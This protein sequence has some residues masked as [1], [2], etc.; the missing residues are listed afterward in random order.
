M[1]YFFPVNGV[2]FDIAVSLYDHVIGRSH[3]AIYC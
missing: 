3:R 2:R 1:S